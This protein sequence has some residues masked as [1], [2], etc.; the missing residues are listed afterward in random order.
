MKWLSLLL[1]CFTV[2]VRAEL[3]F[4]SL[5]KEVKAEPD[6]RKVTCDFYFENKGSETV[7]I[8]EYKAT[9]SCMDVQVNQNGK[10]TYAPGEKGIMRTI[11]DMENFT[12]EVDKNVLVWM[13]GDAKEKPSIVVTVHVII[14]V[15]VDIQPRTMRWNGP[16]PWEAQTMKIRMNHTEPIQIVRASLNNPCYETELKTI[17]VGKEYELIIKP[18]VKPDVQPGMGVIHIETDCKIDKQKKQMAFVVVDQKTPVPPM[19]GAQLGPAPQ[20][21]AEQVKP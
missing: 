18:L 4:D 20:G 16:G 8:A 15:L 6:A 11:F 10:L 7:H 9:C 12:G 1:L 13:Q 5:K 19:G 14:P 17:E 21:D 3:V 2:S